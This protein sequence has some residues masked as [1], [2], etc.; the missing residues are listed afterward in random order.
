MPATPGQPQGLRRTPMREVHN[1]SLL[2]ARKSMEQYAALV[3]TAGR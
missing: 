3:I 2:I 1:F